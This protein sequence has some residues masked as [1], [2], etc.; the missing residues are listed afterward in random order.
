MI[1][2]EHQ[3]LIVLPYKFANAAIDTRILMA[4]GVAV[5]AKQMWQSTI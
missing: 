5:E 2:S 1:H 3:K 4:L